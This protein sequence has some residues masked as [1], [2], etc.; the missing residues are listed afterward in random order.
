[1]S[2]SLELPVQSA[3][4]HVRHVIMNVLIGITHVA[5]IENQRLIKQRPS[6]VA[7]TGQLRDEK[8]N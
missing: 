4:Q 1:M 5:A 6:T 8:T 7:G 3:Y 2:A